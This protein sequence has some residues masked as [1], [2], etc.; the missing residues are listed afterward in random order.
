[1]NQ[2]IYVVSK[3]MGTDIFFDWIDGMD[4]CSCITIFSGDTS[5]A[6]SL[7]YEIPLVGGISSHIFITT[8]AQ[9]QAITLFFSKTH[10]NQLELSAQYWYYHSVYHLTNYH[11]LLVAIQTS[12]TAINL[13]ILPTS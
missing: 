4:G 12:S 6:F 9:L 10:F 13:Y 8:S 2:R 5:L 1:M 7:L 3:K 11:I